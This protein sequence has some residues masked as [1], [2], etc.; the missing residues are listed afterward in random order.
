M[1]EDKFI[2]KRSRRPLAPGRRRF[3]KL[4]AAAAITGLTTSAY[5]FGLEPDHPRV[6]RVTVK[7]PGWPVSAAGLKIGH[8]GDFHCQDDRAQTR[9]SHAVQL[10][11]AEKPDI[12][13]LTGDYIS[14]GFD[15]RWVQQ[16][17][18]ALS[19]LRAMPRGV[20][21]ILGNHDYAD[22][23][24]GDIADA[25]AHA[26]FTVLRNRA[27]PFP[28]VPNAWIIGMESL[29]LSYQNPVQALENVPPSAVKILLVHEPDY[30][31]EAPLGIGL[32]LSGHSHAG[33]VRVPGLPPLYCPA[34]GKR[35]PEGLQQAVNHQVY[36][37]RGVG[38]MGPQIR[39]CCP[40]EIVVLRIV[41]A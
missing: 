33:Q 1:F 36:T 17:A 39:F 10:L 16:S 7:V 8:L 11:L 13:F 15:P 28:G 40:P 27:V 37:T 41:P 20:F 23:R 2:Q 34:F 14:G 21:A 26:G 22:G 31:D 24:S 29:C 3:L 6:S 12:A 19:P 35:Y 18:S 5:G 38:M 4:G 30:A 9:I 25:L 32:Q